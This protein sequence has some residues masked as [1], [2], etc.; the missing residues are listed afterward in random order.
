MEINQDVNFGSDHVL[1]DLTIAVKKRAT[2]CTQARESIKYRWDEESHANKYKNEL[3]QSLGDYMNCIEKS[4]S[5]A[6]EEEKEKEKRK[7]MGK[8]EG[9]EVHRYANARQ[10]EKIITTAYKKVVPHEYLYNNNKGGFRKPDPQLEE[11]VLQR[12]SKQL[13]KYRELTSLQKKEAEVFQQQEAV[14][15]ASKA[16]RRHIHHKQVEEAEKVVRQI[17]LAHDAKNPDIYSLYKSIMKIER[18]PLP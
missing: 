16:V 10:L 1:L 18:N 3:E 11:L 7:V 8:G 15:K 14:D 4:L 9:N 6:R 2:P 12:L 5:M 17:E 13:A